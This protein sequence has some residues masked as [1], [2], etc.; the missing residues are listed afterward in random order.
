MSL[1]AN[2]KFFL[3]L[4]LLETVSDNFLVEQSHLMSQR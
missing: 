3:H 2:P 4:A 1:A